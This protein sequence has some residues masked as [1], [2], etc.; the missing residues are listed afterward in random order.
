MDFSMHLQGRLH[1]HLCWLARL[2]RMID[3]QCLAP[4][5]RRT[6]TPVTFTLLGREEAKLRGWRV[7]NARFWKG[8]GRP[9]VQRFDPRALAC[10]AADAGLMSGLI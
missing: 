8:G 1:G 7:S 4:V 5:P 9:V 3:T 2:C 10:A 6:Q